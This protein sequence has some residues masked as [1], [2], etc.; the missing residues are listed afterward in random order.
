MIKVKFYVLVAL[1]LIGFASNA[2]EQKIGYADW[3]YIFGAMPEFNQIDKDLKA[4]GDLLQLQAQAKTQELDEKMKAF[5]ALPATTPDAVIADKQRELQR[6]DE[7]LKQ[8]NTDAQ[9]SYETKRSQLMDPVFTKVGK[10]IED[11][12]KQ[13][14]YA[15]IL[16]PQLMGGGDI[17]LFTDEKFNI[18]DL[19]LKKM[20]VTPPAKT[21][22]KK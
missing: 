13:H 8:F 17:L 10:A 11:V 7:G 18:S 9:N 19:V 14:G 12:A 20:G 3:N 6:L 5:Q 15:F 16:N 22:P 21:V 2:Q 4:H 1:L